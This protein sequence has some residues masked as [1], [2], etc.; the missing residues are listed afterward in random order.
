MVKRKRTKGFTKHYICNIDMSEKNMF[1][2]KELIKYRYNKNNCLAI[3]VKL[4]LR[5]QYLSV[6]VGVTCCFRAVC[7]SVTTYYSRNSAYILNGN[8]SNFACLLNTAV[9]VCY[10]LLLLY[11]K[12]NDFC[13]RCFKN[14]LQLNVLFLAHK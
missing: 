8:S 9:L 4:I 7:P 2:V 5:Y 12:M 6:T 3:V 1:A 11:Q 14:R 13:G 10:C